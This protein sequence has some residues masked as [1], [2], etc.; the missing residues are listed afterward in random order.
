MDNWSGQSSTQF[1]E[2]D[3]YSNEGKGLISP[4]KCKWKNV[5]RGNAKS[6][7]DE[8]IKQLDNRVTKNANFNLQSPHLSFQFR[9]VLSLHWRSSSRGRDGTFHRTPTSSPSVMKKRTNSRKKSTRSEMEV[10]TFI[11]PPLEAFEIPLSAL[12]LICPF[13]SFPLLLPNSP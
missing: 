3:N 9:F 4:M 6:G 10:S 1:Y 8:S 12:T 2:Y 11:F 13:L 5:R 7:H